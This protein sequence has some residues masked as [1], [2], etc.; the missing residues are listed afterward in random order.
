MCL[1]PAG[2]AWKRT[3]M[4]ESVPFV[5]P[6]CK[7]SLTSSPASFF[8]RRCAREYPIVC[9]IPDFR[10]APDPYIDIEQDRAKGEALFDAG[11]DRTFEQ[12]LR[13][14]YAITREDPP[15]LALHWTAH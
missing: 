15:D 1:A 13:H 12:L 8:C 2:P 14:Y 6:S 9:G 11:K 4:P 5:C 7:G 10:L 3:R